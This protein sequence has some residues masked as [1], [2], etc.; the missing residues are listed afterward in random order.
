MS[1][2]ILFGGPQESRLLLREGW[3]SLPG[4]KSPVEL[5]SGARVREPI[6]ATSEDLARQA[7][8]SFSAIEPER[9]IEPLVAGLRAVRAALE[10]A[11][12][13]PPRD[14]RL[15][16]L[17]RQEELFQRAIA[18]ALGLEATA[19]T[20]TGRRTPWRS[21][22]GPEPAAPFIDAVPGQSFPVRVRLL[23]RSRTE[24][25]F[26]GAELEVPAGWNVAAQPAPAGTLGENEAAT[27][28]FVVMVANG[29]A[30]TW[31][32]WS[33]DSIA[34]TFYRS[35][36]GLRTQAL[37]PPPVHGV[38]RLRAGGEPVELR[39]PLENA[40]ED[41]ALGTR[42][43]PL[44]IVPELSVAFSSEHGVV[45]LGQ[46]EHRVRVAVRSSA[47][48]PVEGSVRLELP[49]GWASSPASSPFVLWK[50]GEESAHAFSIGLPERLE[51]A[52][53]ELRAAASAGRREHRVGWRAITARD[54]G[55]SFFVRPA[56]HSVRAVDVKLLGS[57]R[58]GYVAG[59]GDEVA[60]ALEH[61]G[62][63]AEQLVA[64]DIAA[65][66][67]SRFSTIWIGVRA[68]AVRPEL[69][70]HHQ[71]LMGYVEQGGVLVVQYQ[72][73]EYDGNLAPFPYTMGGNPEE[74]SEES[75]PVTILAPEHPLFTR[76]N[77]I[78][79]ADFAGWVEQR[80]SKFWRTWD[81]R[82]TPLLETHDAGQEPQRGAFLHARH[83]RGH[84]VYCALAWYRQLP[85]GVPGAYRLVANLLSLGAAP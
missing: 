47:K 85:H 35:D 22:P 38:I 58:L 51:A 16:L 49:A 83:G 13:A 21:E 3:R 60:A 57:P 8:A 19:V 1:G 63:R 55:R 73:P 37:P 50:E 20:H 54:L 15:A 67:L 25:R 34:E 59:S 64:E 4:D 40:V 33:R 6:D 32:H 23:N 18:L 65:G 84:F 26:E 48:E 56:R 62:V 41:A 39:V 61:L 78:G 74:V 76:P 69:K 81:E 53:F 12:E 72:T 80:G 28:R 17:R 24:V 70:T 31:P 10:R 71:R 75:A 2:S 44:T 82:Y 29:A 7:L 5:F 43:L 68:Y 14:H 79:A 46:R 27:S 42:L 9:A 36:E 77:A 30:F 45:P 66:D 52:T 11:K